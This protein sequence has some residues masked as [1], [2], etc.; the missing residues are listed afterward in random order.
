MA[1]IKEKGLQSFDQDKVS[2]LGLFKRP[3]GLKGKG[4][5]DTA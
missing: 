4:A 3:Q 1:F 5:R 2:E